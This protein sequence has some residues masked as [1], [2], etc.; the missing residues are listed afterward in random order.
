VSRTAVTVSLL[1]LNGGWLLGQQLQLGRGSTFVVSSRGHAITNAHVV[2]GCEAV[3]VFI[4][5]RV[6][7]ASI[8]ALDSQNDLAL[9]LLEPSPKVPLPFRE[10]RTK[11]GESVVASGYPLQGIGASSLS[12]TSGTVSVLAGLRDD[13]RM[14]QFTAPVQPGNS[15]GPLVDTSGR[16]VGAIASKLSPLWSAVNTGDIPQNVNFA[17]RDSVLKSFLESRGVEYTLAPVQELALT[18]L[19]EQ[20]GKAIGRVDCSHRPSTPDSPNA[21]ES[22]KPSPPPLRPTNEIIRG[23]K[24][25]AL[26]VQG[27]PV[28][29]TEISGELIKWGG[30]SVVQST[31]GADLFLDVIQTGHLNLGTGAGN[32]ASAVLLDGASGAQIWSKTKGGSWAMSGWSN[33]WVGRAI[34][35]ELIKFLESTRQRKK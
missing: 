13:T 12:V 22:A 31:S 25:I 21:L 16:I 33:A 11:L 9:L 6:F 24:T 15:G 34:G 30:L 5:G 7:Q 8:Q 35:K 17:I 28:L 14:I 3:Q 2:S 27:S 32:Q 26:R 4:D 23:A 29:G 18:A 19:A 10:Q 20:V 1:F